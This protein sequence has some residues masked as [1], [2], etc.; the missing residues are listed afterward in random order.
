MMARALA[1]VALAT[2]LVGAIAACGGGRN[3]PDPTV[4]GVAS[5]PRPTVPARPHVF[6]I[7]MENTGLRRALASPPIARLA[8]A[9]M[10]ATN[11]YAVARPS[12]PN[13]L[14][15]T[16]GSTWGITDND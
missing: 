3:G 7:L 5:P 4:Q 13:Y 2:L 1:T 12:L 11:Y 15:M 16:S 6:L 14:A 8:N 9:N 10:L